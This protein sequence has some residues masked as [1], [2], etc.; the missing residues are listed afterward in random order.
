MTV[1]E[2][3]RLAFGRAPLGS[4]ALLDANTPTTDLG[5]NARETP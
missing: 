5:S 3:R 1:L 2:S 4:A